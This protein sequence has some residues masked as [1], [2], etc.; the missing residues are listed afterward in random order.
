M[1]SQTLLLA[2]RPA[3]I[4]RYALTKTLGQLAAFGFDGGDSRQGGQPSAQPTSEADQEG[5]L[6]GSPASRE[7]TLCVK[8]LGYWQDYSI[9]AGMKPKLDAL[10]TKPLLEECAAK[11]SLRPRDPVRASEVSVHVRLCA[12]P[13][14]SYGY[15]GHE[16][17]FG[18]VLPAALARAA[19]AARAGGKTL[20][21]PSVRVVSQ[22]DASKA[23]AVRDLVAKFNASLL[24]GGRQRSAAEDLCYLATSNR[25]VV[26]E[27]TFGWWGAYL[28]SGNAA[29]VNLPFEG[30]M[31]LPYDLEHLAGSASVF[32]HDTK[33]RRFFGRATRNGEIM[34]P[35]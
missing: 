14:H 1:C 11:F 29:E 18:F 7:S 5:L 15:Y 31:P 28:A 10:L 30:T 35:A 13:H 9:F 25:L 3:D 34:F 32:F 27:S 19:D 21:A 2:E 22:C 8:T 17:Y 4:R 26:T 6:G 20:P 23:G 12:T 33:Q 16:N 24:P